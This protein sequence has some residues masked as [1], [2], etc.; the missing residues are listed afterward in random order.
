MMKNLSCF[1]LVLILSACSSIAY[2]QNYLWNGSPYVVRTTDGCFDIYDLEDENRLLIQE[3]LGK[4]TLGIIASYATLGGAE[5]GRAERT[6]FN[7]TKIYFSQYYA[8]EGCEIDNIFAM[9]DVTN[10]SYEV[11]YTCD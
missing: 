1:F 3:C 2:E 7:A 9:P 5:L 11:F 8:S 6:F 10:G 4:Q